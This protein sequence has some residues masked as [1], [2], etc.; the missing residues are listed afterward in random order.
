MKILHHL[1]KMN[2]IGVFLV[3]TFLLS[4]TLFAQTPFG[5]LLEDFEDGGTNMVW[6]IIYGVTLDERFDNPK[7][8]GINSSAK[9]GKTLTDLTNNWPLFGHDYSVDGE[10]VTFDEFFAYSLKVYTEVDSAYILF[11]FEAANAYGAEIELPVNKGVW[12]ELVFVFNDTMWTEWD[13]NPL[14]K[15]IIFPDFIGDEGTR[16]RHEADWF[17]DDITKWDGVPVGVKDA[18]V[19]PV[20]FELKQNFPNPFNP[21]TNINYSL[22]KAGMVTLSIYNV[23]GQKVAV[24]I[25]ND[26]VAG[27]HSFTFNALDLPSG[28]YFYRLEAN[29]QTFV[30]KMLLLK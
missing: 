27:N 16:P 25:N 22:D 17:F 28:T 11:K 24:L 3:M 19:I 29:N 2:I 15:M 21:T 10:E 5:E 30:K 13:T 20:K 14:I 9:V 12:Q 7:T 8:D 6:D 1:I 18:T 26:Q 23:L 4:N